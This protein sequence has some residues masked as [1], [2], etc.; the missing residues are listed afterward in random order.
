MGYSGTKRKGK[1]ILGAELGI[2]SYLG[3][4]VFCQF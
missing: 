2:F 3:G 4:K 1:G